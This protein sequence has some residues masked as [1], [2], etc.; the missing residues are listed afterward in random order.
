MEVQRHRLESRGK[1]TLFAI[2][3]PKRLNSY[4]RS[5]QLV[6]KDTNETV[7]ES[8]GHRRSSIFRKPREMSLEIAQVISDAVDIVL[9]T[10]LLVWRERQSERSKAFG[11][12]DEGLA[13][14]PVALGD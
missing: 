14:I 9:L 2:S 8:H 6:N 1:S 12:F 4:P 7:A 5:L 11:G 13:S 3:R 10:F